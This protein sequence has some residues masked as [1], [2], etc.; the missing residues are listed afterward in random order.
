M[1]IVV[2][3]NGKMAADCIRWMLMSE[4]HIVSHVFYESEKNV[5]PRVLLELI[6]LHQLPSSAI[7]K[8]HDEVNLKV[9]QS[10]S[11]DWIFNINCYQYLRESVLSIPRNGVINFHNGP[12]PRYGGVNIPSWAII[13][14]EAQHG[15]TWHLV[16]AEIDAG[17]ILS[18][19]HFELT[20]R[21]TAAQLMVKCIQVGLQLFEQHWTDWVEGKVQ[22]TPQQGD[23]LYFGL[24]DKVPH[25]G[26]LSAKHTRVEWDRMVR[27]LHLFPYPNDVAHAHI[28]IQH[29]KY[30]VIAG[31]VI[32]NDV[33]HLI[34][35][36]QLDQ[37]IGFVV[38]LS[39]GHY[40]ITQLAN[41]DWKLIKPKD[42]ELI[43]GGSSSMIE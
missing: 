9:M 10:I 8:I 33:T 24:K 26:L 3:G 38:Q 34:G 2:I 22:P 1:K 15:V 12:L 7:V 35:T 41:E 17:E 19:F 4:S 18:Q 29:H 36:I 32:D 6:E 13:N 43:C 25:G 31:K 40:L 30:F 42:V 11:P 27:A 20:D 39:D 16:N 23:R 14:G 28:K 5:N 21:M 37:T